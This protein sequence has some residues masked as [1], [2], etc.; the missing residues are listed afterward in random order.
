MKASLLY[1]MIGLATIVAQTTVLGL[2][3]F[4]GAVSDLLIP[5][6]VF[7]SL[8]RPNRQ[9]VSLAL[10]LGLVM[11]L[12]SGGIFGLYLSIYFWIFLSARRLS[13]YFDVGKTIFQ[14]FLI[15]LYVLGEQ[16]VF[17]ASVPQPL[18][19]SELLASQLM[20]I[21]AQTLFGAFTGPGILLILRRL[22]TRFQTRASTTRRESAE[23]GIQ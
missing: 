14:A 23:L 20:P 19:G 13:R 10:A 9:G 8:E 12:V 2:P 16:I 17:F 3:V 22:Q 7:L 21:L 6:I 1:L 15:G 5:L 4:H 11:D 18:R